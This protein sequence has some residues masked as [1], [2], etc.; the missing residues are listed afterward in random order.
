MMLDSG[1]IDRLDRAR[2]S[3]LGLL[4]EEVVGVGVEIVLHDH[5][6]NP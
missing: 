5:V 3:I 6:S 2:A 4:R 1:P